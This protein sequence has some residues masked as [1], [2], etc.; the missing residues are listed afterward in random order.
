MRRVARRTVAACV[1]DYAGEMT[2]LRAF[3][4]AALELDPD[5]PDEGRTM[6][7]CTP[8]ELRALWEAAGLRD[9]TTGELVVAADYA[10]FDDYLVSVPD[11]SRAV[12]RL[13]RLARR[14]TPRCLAGSVLP[15]ARL[16]G[17]AVLAERP[18]VVRHRRGLSGIGLSPGE[19]TVGWASVQE[20]P[21]SA[22]SRSTATRR[23]GCAALRSAQ[24]AR[25]IPIGMV[26]SV[27]AISQ[28][29][30][31]VGG[32][33]RPWRPTGRRRVGRWSASVRAGGA[34]CVA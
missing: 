22:G 12:G 5:A 8:G 16:A 19:G 15:P 1:W 23:A 20:C 4:D 11:R 7:V 32:R 3:W 6:P 13:L 21:L 17:R 28:R 9:V 30:T 2:M 31:V 33:P 29:R 34:C 24:R 18:R 27:D 25:A 14:R 10:D 26:W